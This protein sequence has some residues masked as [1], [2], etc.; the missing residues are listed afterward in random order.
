MSRGGTKSP[1]RHAKT[2]KI[3][4]LSRQDYFPAP[5]ADF[6]GNVNRPMATKTKNPVE[7]IRANMIS[8][9][10]IHGVDLVAGSYTPHKD[11]P[12]PKLV[13]REEVLEALSTAALPSEIPPIDIYLHSD[14]SLVVLDGAHR[15]INAINRCQDDPGNWGKIRV[16]QWRGGVRDAQVYSLTSNL[17]FAHGV[18]T[19]SEEVGVVERLM[20]LGFSVDEIIE[21]A[22]RANKRWIKKIEEVC[23]ATPGVLEAVKSGEI[24]LE[25]GS[26]IARK[27]PLAE[28]QE[29]VDAAIALEKEIGGVATRNEIG[30]RKTRIKVANS[31]DMYSML[32][33]IFDEVEQNYG[34]RSMDAH[35]EGQWDCL[36]FYFRLEHLDHSEQMAHLRPLYEEYTEKVLG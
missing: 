4:G 32:W 22:G 36:M 27:V 2:V 24:S 12:Q 15:V 14:G 3:A 10:E 31:N 28:Q 34:K 7:N 30:V 21:K 13:I 20:T 25:T 33:G 1:R 11:F 16:A 8:L 23:N 5:V 29:K 19:E 18:L 6:W 17:D 26:K 35:T 9:D